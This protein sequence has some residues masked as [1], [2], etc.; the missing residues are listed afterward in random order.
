MTKISKFEMG[1]IGIRISVH[2]KSSKLLKSYGWIKLGHAELNNRNGFD[3]VRPGITK[4]QFDQQ[5]W[6]KLADT[7]LEAIAIWFC[8]AQW[9]NGSSLTNTQ[10]KNRAIIQSDFNAKWPTGRRIE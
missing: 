3:W 1:W 10:W 6:T 2:G 4:E 8:D 7:G 5:D 9:K